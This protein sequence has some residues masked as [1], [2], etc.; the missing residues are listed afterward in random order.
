M[1]KILRSTVKTYMH[2]VLLR[3]R[4]DKDLNQDEMAYSLSMSTRAYAAFEAGSSCCGF[5]TFLIFVL[6]YCP[7]RITF[8]VGLFDT[9]DE[10]LSIKNTAR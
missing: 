1:R 3:A 6:R 2:D 4:D 8:L 7:D 5:M 10:A 9:L